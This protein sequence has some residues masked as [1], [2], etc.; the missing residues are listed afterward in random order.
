MTAEAWV[1]RFGDV[2][3]EPAAH[4]ITRG[5]VDLSVEPKAYAVLVALLQEHAAA[6][7]SLC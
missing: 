7:E 4:R 5:G 2:E 3:V 6:G 1:Y